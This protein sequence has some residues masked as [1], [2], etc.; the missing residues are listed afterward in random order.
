MRDRA[1]GA[2]AERER[3]MRREKKRGSREGNSEQIRYNRCDE[4]EECRLGADNTD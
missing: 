4:I 3:R 1:R 2:D